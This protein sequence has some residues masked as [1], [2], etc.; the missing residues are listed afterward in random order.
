MSQQITRAHVEMFRSN[1]MLTAQQGNSRLRNTVTEEVGIGKT[2]FFEQVKPT[3]MVR[4]TSRHQPSPQIDTPHARRQA[5]PDTF[6]WGDL[7]DK[8]DRVRALIDPD[9]SYLMNA[10][11]A[12]NRQIDS[13]IIPAATGVSLVNG[14][15]GNIPTIVALPA[16]Q[17]IAVNFVPSGAAVNSGLT[18]DKL[19]EAKRIMG[20]NDVDEEEEF[21]ISVSQQQ[22]TDLL[23]ET[24]VTSSDFNIV[25]ALVEGKVDKY[26][27]FTFHRTQLNLIDT[28]TDIRTAFAYVKSGIGL[29][30]AREITVNVDPSRSDRNFETYLHIEMDMGATRLEEEKVV[31]IL[32]DESPP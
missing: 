2:H 18:V 31:S 9:S 8:S 5:S 20:E 19:I 12:A 4:K 27:G 26:M 23:R 24:E 6:V 14:G 17:I 15:A 16:F 11:M 7:I 13:I 30:I 10:R 22:I 3:K 28:A 29:A 1:L 32:C 21:H 25:R